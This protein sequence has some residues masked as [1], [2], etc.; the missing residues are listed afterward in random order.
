MTRKC[1]KMSTNKK[2]SVVSLSTKLIHLQRISLRS[3]VSLALAPLKKLNKSVTQLIGDKNQAELRSQ[4]ESA[5]RAESPNI[6]ST[7]RLWTDAGSSAGLL[8]LGH[9]KPAARELLPNIWISLKVHRVTGEQALN[10]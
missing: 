10:D 7:Q 3:A 1:F 8:K 6:T 4:P 5:D 9:S 2:S